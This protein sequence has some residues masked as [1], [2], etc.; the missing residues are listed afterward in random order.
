MLLHYLR[1]LYDVMESRD[2]ID[3]MITWRS[4]ASH[5]LSVPRHNLSF[6]YCDFRISAPKRAY[7]I[8]YCLTF[9]SL[10]HCLYL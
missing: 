2:V 9:C 10:K 5:S 6:C 1:H 7:G 4:S 8:P 3:H